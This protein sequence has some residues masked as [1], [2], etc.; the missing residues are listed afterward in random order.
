MGLDWSDWGRWARGLMGAC[1]SG[2]A[3]SLSAGGASM[4]VVPKDVNLQTPEGFHNLI[5]ITG[6]TAFGA[7]ITSLGKY[8]QQHPLPEDE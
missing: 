5:L 4:Y 8:L 2:V 1:I 6:I 7:F 3:G